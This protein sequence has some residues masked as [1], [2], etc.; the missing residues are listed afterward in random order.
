MPV[1]METWQKQHE[2]QKHKGELDLLE[3]GFSTFFLNRTNRSGI[4]SGGVIGGKGQQG[5]YK[6]DARYNKKALIER[7]KHIIVLRV[8]EMSNF[9]QLLFSLVV[10]V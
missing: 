3:L 1:T 10:F 7:I 6:M 2:L 8:I 5:K 4:L 9:F